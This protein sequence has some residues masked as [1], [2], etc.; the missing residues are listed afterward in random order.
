VRYLHSDIDSLERSALIRDLRL[1]VFDCLIGINLLREGLDIPEV[2]LVAVLDADKEGFLRNRTSLIQT[3]GRA[4]RNV[5]GRAIL[6]ADRVTD[7]M[8]AAMDEMSRRRD[9]QAAYNIEHGITPKTVVKEVR[10]LLSIETGAGAAD[11]QRGGHKSRRRAKGSRQQVSTALAFADQRS[12]NLQIAKLRAEMLAASKQLDFELAASI[13]DEV[14][15]L[16]KF[17]LEIG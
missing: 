15:R 16:E 5:N 9:R 17:G 2:T 14:F 12:L 4:S 13:R 1:R 6:Y 7:S 3:C 10:E 8:Q 11:G